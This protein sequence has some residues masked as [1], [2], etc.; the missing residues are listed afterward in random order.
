MTPGIALL[1][2]ITIAFAPHKS[3]RR[4]TLPGEAA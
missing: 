4:L 2:R 1:C 3:R